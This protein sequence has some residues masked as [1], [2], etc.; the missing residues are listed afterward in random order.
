MTFPKFPSWRYGPKGQSVIVNS[1]DETPSGFVDHPS[2]VE[3]AEPAPDGVKTATAPA[4]STTTAA[5]AA[6][7]TEAKSQTHIDPAISAQSGV[8][9]AGSTP[10]TGQGGAA[11]LTA[12][13][14]EELDADGHPFDPAL[15][16]AT[17]SKTKNG[18]WRMK[19]GV[20]RPAPKPGYPLDL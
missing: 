18:L 1:E 3:G 5:N 19:V 15:H 16:A 4:N 8:G 2:K 9:G 6:L 13:K 14:G 11:E 7:S 12:S 17:K 10:A 20:A